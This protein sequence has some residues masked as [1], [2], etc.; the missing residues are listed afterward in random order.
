MASSVWPSCFYRC[1][2]AVKSGWKSSE[3]RLAFWS[4]GQGEEEQRIKLLLKKNLQL[5][6]TIFCLNCNVIK[7][8]LYAV[9]SVAP[10]GFSTQF[11]GRKSTMYL[12]YFFIIKFLQFYL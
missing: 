11:V 4:T 6:G 5:A 7:A 10:F 9:K 3:E 1:A 8:E 12:V 2:M